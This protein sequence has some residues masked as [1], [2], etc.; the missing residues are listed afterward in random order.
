MKIMRNRQLINEVC[1]YGAQG[2]NMNEI[3]QS[4][5]DRLNNGHREISGIVS[6]AFKMTLPIAIEMGEILT[7]QKADLEHG[8]WLPWVEENLIFSDRSARD[9]MRFYDRRE[10]LKSATV[11]DLR[12]ARKLLTETKEP[13]DFNTFLEEQWNQ[14]IAEGERQNDLYYP[15]HVWSKFLFDL[16]QYLIDRT[17]NIEKL[18]FMA[19]QIREWYNKMILPFI[20][21]G[22]EGQNEPSYNRQMDP[23]PGN[24][25]G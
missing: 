14:A 11:A 7:E 20:D 10:E 16:A 23:A 17:D 13:F 6:G 15:V 1:A 3:E 21:N 2:E 19:G 8:Q 12:D 18:S 25:T 5:I 4:R 22:S 9:Y 24:D